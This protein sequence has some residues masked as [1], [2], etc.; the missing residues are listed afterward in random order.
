MIW[1]S[2]ALVFINPISAGMLA[3]MILV[4]RSDLQIGPIAR[5][6]AAV[7]IAGLIFNAAENWALIHEYQPPRTMAWIAVIVGLH[8][9]IWA[10][11]FRVIYLRSHEE[12]AA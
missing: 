1:A 3:M 6:F 11:F 4:F 5:T 2:Y 7:L 12:Q 9:V 10:L 8:G